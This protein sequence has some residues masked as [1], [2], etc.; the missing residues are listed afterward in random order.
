ME[1]LGI[2]LEALPYVAAIV[3]VCVGGWAFTTW[4]RIKHSYPLETS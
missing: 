2:L 3:A 4:L 1:K